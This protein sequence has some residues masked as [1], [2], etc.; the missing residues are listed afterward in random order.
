MELLSFAAGH[1]IP[2]LHDHPMFTAYE[3]KW[4][5]GRYVKV[6]LGSNKKRLQKTMDKLGSN[7]FR[8]DQAKLTKK[9]HKKRAKELDA[10]IKREAQYI[11]RALAEDSDS[12]LGQDRE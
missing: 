11:G 6:E 9:T 1:A 8:L 4:K 12:D 2:N 10:D 3:T 5:Q 7:F